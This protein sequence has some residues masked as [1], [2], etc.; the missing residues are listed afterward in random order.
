LGNTRKSEDIPGPCRQEDVRFFKPSDW[1]RVS[2]SQIRFLGGGRLITKFGNLGLALQYA[3]P[4]EPSWK[5]CASSK[6]S[7]KSIQRWLCLSLQSL[8][9]DNTLIV[10]EFIHPKLCWDEED[11]Q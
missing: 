6:I 1:Y 10:E 8:L 7:K 9:S 3:Y 11:Y 2:V 4:D 5:P